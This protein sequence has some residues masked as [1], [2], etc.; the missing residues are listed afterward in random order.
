MA[1]GVRSQR[2][3][4]HN[5]DYPTGWTGNILHSRLGFSHETL[6]RAPEKTPGTK[7][8]RLPTGHL[9]ATRRDISQGIESKISSTPWVPTF[10]TIAGAHHHHARVAV[11]GQDGLAEGRPAAEH[12]RDDDCQWVISPRPE[13]SDTVQ[14]VCATVPSLLTRRPCRAKWAV[15]PV[16]REIDGI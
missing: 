13:G 12:V 3:D 8:W 14:S 4:R 7:S 15:P 10:S 2:N 6:P 11:R 1:W 9:H 5:S 16:K